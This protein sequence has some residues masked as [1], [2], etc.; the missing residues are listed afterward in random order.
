LSEHWV[1]EN[2]LVLGIIFAAA[3]VSLT[4]IVSAESVNRNVSF[5]GDQIS[6]R[7]VSGPIII[8]APAA[9]P[10]QATPAPTAQAQQQPA[11]PPVKVSAA[12]LKATGR[13]AKGA[14]NPTITI[15]EFSDFECPFCSRANPTIA[16]LMQDYPNKVKVVFKHFPLGFHPNAQ[17]ASEAAE[18]AYAQG[19]FWEMHD[20]LFAN[21]D[22]LDDANLKKYAVDLKLDTA[23]FDKC[24]DDGEKAAV[25]KQDASDGEKVGVGGTPTFFINGE[26]LVG[27]QPASAFKE[28]I[29][30][31]LAG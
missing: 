2:T 7:A 14:A 27:A 12:D 3:L 16:Q 23:K 8:Q 1:K 24:L 10:A 15:V 9:A 26:R 4:I 28:I 20:K 18:C 13:P 30:K 5:L 6:S 29:D 19:K 22:A 31:Q 17:K 21:Q 11:E 25:V